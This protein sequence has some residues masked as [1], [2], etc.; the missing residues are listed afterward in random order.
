MN[1][2]DE[3][4]SGLKQH[5]PLH[6]V[7]RIALAVSL[8]A[9]VILAAALL[10]ISDV[11]GRSYLDVIQSYRYTQEALRPALLVA[12]LALLAIAGGLTWLATLYGSF[13][14]AGPLYRM[15]RNLE[16]ARRFGPV[17]PI[18][19]RQTDCLQAEAHALAQ[20]TTRLR[21]H[22]TE[23]ETLA[24]QAKQALEDGGCDAQQ[25]RHLVEQLR[26]RDDRV[27]V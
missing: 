26:E 8:A 25:W 3:R 15:Q 20:A 24:T 11:V 6:L 4:D 10:L 18:P 17:A 19:I 16:Q 5:F 7:G 21:E 27:R 14:I 9:L 22:Y 23:V 2:R 12:G 1:T 13:R